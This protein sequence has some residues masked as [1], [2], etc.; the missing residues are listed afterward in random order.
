M[1]SR[2]K[3]ASHIDPPAS[4]DAIMRKACP[5]R[6]ENPEP[7]KDIHREELDPW[8]GIRE[9]PGSDP[10]VA[11]RPYFVRCLTSSRHF[12]VLS[13]HQVERGCDLKLPSKHET[14]K[15]MPPITDMTMRVGSEP[16]RRFTS[17]A[18]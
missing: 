5:Y 1:P 11:P 4:S 13:A 15:P 10:A 17:L 6:G 7:G 14:D 12:K 3:R 18:L 8:P 16:C 2:A 9:Q